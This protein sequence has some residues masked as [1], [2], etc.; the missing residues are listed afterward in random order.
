[1]KK[2]LIIVALVICAGG[3]SWPEVEERSSTVEQVAQ[4]AQILATATAPYTAG[5]GGLVAVIAGAVG[6][7]A[8]ALSNLAKSKKVKALAMA[9]VEAAEETNGGGQKLVNSAGA[10]GVSTEI[11]AAYN[12]SK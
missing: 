4:K 12:A 7:V 1:M 8:G 3:C 2:I 10:N 5:Y 9:A 6:T 11:R